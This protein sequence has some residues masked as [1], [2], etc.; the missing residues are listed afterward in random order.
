M[1][2]AMRLARL[3]LLCITFA[4]S[5]AAQN[6]MHAAARSS[7]VVA[8]RR[9]RVAGY[10][11]AGRC[12][13][14]ASSNELP[15]RRRPP[16]ISRT[17]PRVTEWTLAPRGWHC[18]NVYGS[19]GAF[20]A[21]TPEAM[22]YDAIVAILRSTGF[23][24]RAVIHNYT[25]GFTSGRDEIAPVIQRVFPA[26]MK[27]A[28]NAAANN[29]EPPPHYVGPYPEDRLRYLSNEAVEFETPAHREGIGTLQSHLRPDDGEIVGAHL[30]V[31][32]RGDCCDLVSVAVRLPATDRALAF[33][34]D[35][36]AGR[37]RDAT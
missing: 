32:D 29:D 2:L 23:E 3:P 26:H 37:A 35:H 31:L 13:E 21:V 7:V 11:R 28:R 25:L 34:V 12:A 18:F 20:L 27:F 36:Q 33:T 19:D 14:K 9:L 6:G 8:I 24:G 5:V 1:L 10:E 4:T 30:L 22:G 15:P 17:T 16:P